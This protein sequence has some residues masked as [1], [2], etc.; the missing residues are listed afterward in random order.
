MHLIILYGHSGAGKSHRRTTDPELSRLEYVD[1]GDVVADTKGGPL[2]TFEAMMGELGRRI[3]AT[4]P[5]VVVEGHFLPASASRAWMES[6]I[7]E[8]GHTA[9]WIEC[10]A[11]LQQHVTRLVSDFQAGKPRSRERIKQFKRDIR[12]YGI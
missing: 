9:E 1:L 12:R 2:D 5:P 7:L 6:W 8:R 4:T 3:E 11:S 10:K